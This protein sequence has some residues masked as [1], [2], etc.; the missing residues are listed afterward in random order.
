[1]SKDVAKELFV[2]QQRVDVWSQVAVA[3]NI[4]YL[5]QFCL[6]FVPFLLGTLYHRSLHVC[7]GTDT[8]SQPPEELGANVND[9]TAEQA[10]H[11]FFRR[12]W[13]TDEAV[14]VP[15]ASGRARRP[16]PCPGWV[17]LYIYF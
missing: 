16:T 3:P 14:S 2:Q 8:K 1:V 15:A 11:R 7:T 5:W 12:N 17:L 10:Q 4:V 13:A 6:H 9:F